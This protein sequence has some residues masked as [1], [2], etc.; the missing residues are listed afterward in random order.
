MLASKAGPWFI[1]PHHQAAAAAAAA[2]ML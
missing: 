2:T 1:T